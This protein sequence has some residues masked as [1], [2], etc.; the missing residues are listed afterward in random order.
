MKF[1]TLDCG[2]C[3]A[4]T[5]EN[6]DPQLRQASGLSWAYHGRYFGTPDCKTCGLCWACHGPNFGFQIV[7]FVIYA[8]LAACHGRNF[9][10]PDC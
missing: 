8:G 6:L 1:G 4:A 3:R 2:L 10:S 9:G 7:R 5:D